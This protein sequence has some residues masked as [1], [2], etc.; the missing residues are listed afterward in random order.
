MNE[1]L[2]S[3]LNG[4]R[5]TE[6]RCTDRTASYPPTA[7]P[8]DTGTTSAVVAAISVLPALRNEPGSSGSDPCSCLIISDESVVE[9]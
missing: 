6:P 4:P 8:A 2:W 9:K 7:E 3:E 1:Q 5:D